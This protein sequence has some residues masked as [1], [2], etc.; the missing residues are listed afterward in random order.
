MRSLT[1]AGGA[2]AALVTLG[3]ALT[4]CGSDAKT[5]AA[6]S[7]A[8]TPS[9]SSAASTSKA[10]PEAAGA[11]ETIADYLKQNNI[12]ETLVHRGDPGTPK[13]DLPTPE[14]WKDSGAQTPANAWSALVFTGDPA[15]ASDP[16]TIVVKMSKLT[17]KVDQAKVFEY[18]PGELKNLPG[19]EGMGDGQA[20]KLSGFDAFQ[21]GGTFVKNDAKRMIAQ[22]TVAIPAK[23]G[24]GLF[25]PKLAASGAEDQM[26]PL[27]GATS[28]IDATAVITP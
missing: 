17:G 15:M 23:D 13:L 2:A 27:V 1:T 20:T 22:K 14:G 21:I 11:N 24:S 10:A 26:Q 4:G 18:A 8:S 9:S 7:S 16:P 19:F 6:S 5:T 12:T 28:Q 25:V 3:L